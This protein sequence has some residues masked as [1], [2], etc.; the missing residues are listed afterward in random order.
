MNR[1]Q[2]KYLSPRRPKPLRLGAAAPSS[3]MELPGA[4][5]G[6]GMGAWDAGTAFG[7]GCSQ[8]PQHQLPSRGGGD[9]NALPAWPRGFGEKYELCRN[10]SWLLQRAPQVWARASLGAI[11]CSYPKSCS[12]LLVLCPRVN[13]S[14]G[15]FSRVGF[16]DV[17]VQL[18]PGFKHKPNATA[19]STQDLSKNGA[20]CPQSCT[21]PRYRS[22]IPPLPDD[23]VSLFPSQ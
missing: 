22:C 12:R 17:E 6:A 18:G 20:P 2:R 16:R 4:R 1:N 19:S 21:P 11:W 9:G 14:L 7:S 8:T 3:S 15:G 10:S 5:R 23:A 13:I